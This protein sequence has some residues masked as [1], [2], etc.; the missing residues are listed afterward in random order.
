MDLTLEEASA[1]VKLDAPTLSRALASYVS[2]LSDDAP[3]DRFVNGNRLKG[4]WL[5]YCLTAPSNEDV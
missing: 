2:I 3:Y 1:R 4:N 5:V